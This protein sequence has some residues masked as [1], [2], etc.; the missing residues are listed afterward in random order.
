VGRGGHQKV[1]RNLFLPVPPPPP[2]SPEFKCQHCPRT[3]PS[4]RRLAGH[5]TKH[6]DV[7]KARDRQIE[8]ERRRRL[9]PAGPQ[10]SVSQSLSLV[11][12]PGSADLDFRTQVFNSYHT[13][14]HNYPSP[15]FAGSGVMPFFAGTGTGG[16]APAQPSSAATGGG[17]H[18]GSGSHVGISR[19]V[20]QKETA[21]YFSWLRTSAVPSFLSQTGS[22]L[23]RPSFA[24]PAPVA[25]AEG[26]NGDGVHLGGQQETPE[27]NQEETADGID[28]TLRL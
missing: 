21:Q 12:G 25:Q 11:P 8:K 22:G 15:S 4:A 18:V 5:Q 17:G 6:R 9:A 26:R 19:Q 2:S 16:L 27:V 20:N 3:F 23:P 10:V 28:L 13:R 24:A 1:H 14:M 7:L